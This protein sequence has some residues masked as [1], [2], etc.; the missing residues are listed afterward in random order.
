MSSL[1]EDRRKVMSRLNAR[2]KM[3]SD[4]SQGLLPICPKCKKG[5]I[6]A[7]GRS[8]FYCDNPDCKV[9]YLILRKS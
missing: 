9:E 6:H 4:A 2:Q 3:F 1:T 8:Y 5:H 7:K